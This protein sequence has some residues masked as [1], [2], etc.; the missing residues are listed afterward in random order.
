MIVDGIDYAEDEVGVSGTWALDEMRHK[1]AALREHCDS[2]G[3][4]AFLDLE[5]LY[6]DTVIYASREGRAAAT[7]AILG[8]GELKCPD[9]TT[10]LMKSD[11]GGCHLHN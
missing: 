11:D 5:A 7:A 2:A 4:K 6:W 8:I 9:G 3:W 10:I 1:Q